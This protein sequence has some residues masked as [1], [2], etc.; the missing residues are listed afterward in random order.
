VGGKRLPAIGWIACGD[1]AFGILCALGGVAVGGFS[2]GGLAI[3]LFALGG[4]GVGLFAF[5][6]FSIGGI[7]MGGGALGYMAMGGGAVG[8]LAASGGAAVARYFAE[9]GGAI[10]LH[11][12]DAA[13][14]AFMR[15]SFFFSHQ[16]AIFDVLIMYSWLVPPL[17]TLLYKRRSARASRLPSP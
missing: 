13:A 3:G 12:N 16:W 6:G 4:F 10:A 15:R 5:G 8:W 17:L 2:S 11:A 7:V 9:G 14:R 1:K